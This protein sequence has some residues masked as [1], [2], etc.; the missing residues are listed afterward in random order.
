MSKLNTL[1]NCTAKALIGIGAL[2]TFWSTMITVNYFRT[3]NNVK[4]TCIEDRCEYEH[5]DAETTHILNYL[6]GKEEIREEERKKVWYLVPKKREFNPELYQRLWQTEIETGSPKIKW[7]PLVAEEDIFYGYLFDNYNFITN[8]LMIS[9]LEP[10]KGLA[11]EWAHSE[12]F[13]HDPIGS[14]VRYLSDLLRIA[15]RKICG[16]SLSYA[17]GQ[18]YETF[19]SIEYEAHRIIEPQLRKRLK[20]EVQ[21]RLGRAVLQAGRYTRMCFERS[22]D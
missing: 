1:W 8:S 10:E 18:E 20:A 12:Q 11:A 9:I 13:N 6:A 2:A 14:N 4:A 21:E 7:C 17:H 19:G 15:K 16:S 3:Q 5:P 22:F